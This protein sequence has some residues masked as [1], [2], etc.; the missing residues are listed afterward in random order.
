M[1]IVMSAKQFCLILL[2]MQMVCF[3]FALLFLAPPPPAPQHGRFVH[4]E[5]CHVNIERVLLNLDEMMVAVQ[6][7]YWNEGH[8]F[9]ERQLYNSKLHDLQHGLR[10]MIESALHVASV[11]CLPHA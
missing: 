8:E 7:M 10:I 2:G 11:N 9:Y 4:N 3:G 1:A 6:D 5:E